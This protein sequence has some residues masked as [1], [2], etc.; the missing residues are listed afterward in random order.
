MR[1]HI[2]EKTQESHKAKTPEA[3]D[4][5]MKDIYNLVKIVDKFLP[6]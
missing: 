2:V 4:P 6:W 5:I 1:K 3:R